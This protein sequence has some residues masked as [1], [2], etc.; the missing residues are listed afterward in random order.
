ML[1]ACPNRKE[2]LKSITEWAGEI[3]FQS[4]AG[5]EIIVFKNAA[6]YCGKHGLFTRIKTVYT[7]RCWLDVGRKPNILP[8]APAVLV[9]PWSYK[10]WSC[11]RHSFQTCPFL[12][13]TC[14]R[15]SE[16]GNQLF[17]LEKGLPQ[18]LKTKTVAAY[19]K[20]WYRTNSSHL[21]KNIFYF[22]ILRNR[23]FY[24]LSHREFEKRLH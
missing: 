7:K 2:C 10:L 9:S 4:I 17:R 18:Y 14:Q 19:T 5:A 15:E 24:I 11:W 12:L 16:R 8:C 20:C 3:K 6:Q 1:H 21:K 13:T 23:K 22:L